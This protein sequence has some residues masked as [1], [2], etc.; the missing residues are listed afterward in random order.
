MN[1]I[2]VQHLSDVEFQLKVLNHALEL[3]QVTYRH[4][5][6]W[7][8]SE[9]PG[10]RSLALKAKTHGLIAYDRLMAVNYV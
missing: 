9:N 3:M 1:T 7:K 10:T 4:W 5:E 8:D 2:N 6:A